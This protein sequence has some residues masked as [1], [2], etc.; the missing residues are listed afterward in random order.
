MHPER[1]LTPQRAAIHVSTVTAFVADLHLG[2]SA[3]R[4]RGDVAVLDPDDTLGR[5][6]TQLGRHPVRRSTSILTTV[7]KEKLCRR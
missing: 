2:Y 3:A 4:Q 6:C 7:C 1:V 5:L